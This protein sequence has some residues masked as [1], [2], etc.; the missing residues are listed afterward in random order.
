[1]REDSADLQKQSTRLVRRTYQLHQTLD[2]LQAE[3]EGKIH[4]GGTAGEIDPAEEIICHPLF[5][6]GHE[7]SHYKTPKDGA[8]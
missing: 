3:L 7:T 1:M 6:P 2:S 5:A 8:G 4:H